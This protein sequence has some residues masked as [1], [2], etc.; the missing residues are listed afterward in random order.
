[1]KTLERQIVRKTVRKITIDFR[2]LDLDTLGAGLNPWDDI[3]EGWEHALDLEWENPATRMP[4]FASV[5]RST[6]E[7]ADKLVGLSLVSNWAREMCLP[8]RPDAGRSDEL[9]SLETGT[10]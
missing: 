5:V 3:D 8:C 10:F 1:M 2:I 4:D 9:F 7:L 6:D